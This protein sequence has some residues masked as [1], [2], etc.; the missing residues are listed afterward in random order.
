MCMQEVSKCSYLV[1][2]CSQLLCPD[3]A[4]DKLDVRNGD[5]RLAAGPAGVLDVLHALEGCFPARYAKR[6]SELASYGTSAVVLRDRIL[7]GGVSLS[8]KGNYESYTAE[9]YI[10]CF[11]L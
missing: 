7:D 8:C 11:Q 3:L 2:V 9:I 5:D 6:K 4:E 10:E 1:Q